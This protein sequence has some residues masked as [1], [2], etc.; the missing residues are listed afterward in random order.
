MG[1]N[2]LQDA[3]LCFLHHDQLQSQCENKTNRIVV[4]N[5]VT[6]QDVLL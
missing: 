1:Q 3:L 2:H 4:M 6:E 5:S